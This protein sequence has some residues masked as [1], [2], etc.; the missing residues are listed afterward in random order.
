MDNT[1]KLLVDISNLHKTYVHLGKKISVLKGL[2]LEVNAGEMCAIVGA[3]GAG[4]STFLHVVGTLDMPTSGTIRIDSADVTGL[5]ERAL[6]EFRNVTIGFVFQFHHLLPEF[7]ALENTM[8]PGLI[9]HMNPSELEDQAAH[10]LGEVGLT[11]RVTHKPG[12][13]SGG[14]Q[15]RVAL[16]RALVL[17]PKLLLADEP[18]GNLDGRTSDA[19]HDL[20]FQMNER[21][22][23]TMLLVTH[24]PSLAQRM[25]RTLR[26]ESGI[27]TDV[28]SGSM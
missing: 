28:E 26:L 13:L 22:N 21:Y 23:T 16:A 7:S 9:R 11:H 12:E 4:K 18:T 27:V 3:S 10:I 25:P 2:S 20:F 5:P 15:Q 19:I 17:R 14:E 24:N 6:A 8:M 1:S